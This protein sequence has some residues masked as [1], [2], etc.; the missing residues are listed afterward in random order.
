MVGRFTLCTSAAQS[1]GIG[2]GLLLLLKGTPMAEIFVVTAPVP[3][4][5]LDELRAPFTVVRG[6]VYPY[7]AMAQEADIITSCH[8]DGFGL[9]EYGRTELLDKFS[10][11]ILGF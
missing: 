9:G 6:L 2:L 11:I 3:E 4:D 10:N 8:P 5:F 1:V 7:A